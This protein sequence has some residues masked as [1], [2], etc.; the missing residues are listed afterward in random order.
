VTFSQSLDSKANVTALDF[1]HDG[2]QLVVADENE[3]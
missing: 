3:T 2:T 1:S